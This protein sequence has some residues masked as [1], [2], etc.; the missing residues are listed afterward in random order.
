[1]VKMNTG[2]T[3]SGNKGEAF[4]SVDV[5]EEQW[6][7]LTQGIVEDSLKKIPLSGKKQSPDSVLKSF[8]TSKINSQAHPGNI[9]EIWY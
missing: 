2:S 1:M 5:S 6:E 3:K 4:G 9:P 8:I 7:H